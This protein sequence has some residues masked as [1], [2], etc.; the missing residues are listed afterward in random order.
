MMIPLLPAVIREYHASDVTGRHALLSVPASVL[1]GRGAGLGEVQR[2]RS[3]ANRLSSPR[4]CLR[5]RAISRKRCRI[6][7]FGF[8]SRASSS[9]CGG[10]SLG[11]VQSYI[12]DVTKEDQRDLAY[13][14]YGAVFGMAFIV[15]PGDGRI[16]DEARPCVAVLRA[17]A[18]L[19]D[20][21]S[22]SRR[23]CSRRAA[24]PSDAPQRASANR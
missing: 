17:A 3:G 1:D 12:A 23:R 2:P 6:R 19:K 5:W 15:G 9:G 11:A 4:K 8:L 24:G 14:L 7:W 10:G 13:S 22:F 20:S 18:A 21:T 16:F